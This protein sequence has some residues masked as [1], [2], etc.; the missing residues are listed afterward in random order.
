MRLKIILQCFAMVFMIFLASGCL[1]IEQTLRFN[2]DAS[3]VVTYA[4]AYPTAREEALKAAQA[5]IASN[6]R[7]Q[8]PSSA[9][10]LGFMDENT[11][12]AFFSG[13]GVE[14]RQY[15][16]S[17]GREKTSITIIV[18]SR[19]GAKTLNNGLFGAFQLVA[20]NGATRFDAAMPAGASW[21]PSGRR[22]RLRKLCKDFSITL[23]VIAPSE[24]KA[25]NAV[26]SNGDTASWSLG[27]DGPKGA[28]VFE[29]PASM[30]VEW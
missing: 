2:K 23:T 7:K 26:K 11:V 13:T 17:I 4:Y 22:E 24:I 20:K 25:S 1:T 10:G 28:T 27:M 30:Y 29:P 3:L 6:I 21:L 8:E 16:K 5:E 14:L 15:K 19:D 9:L 12:S 18:L